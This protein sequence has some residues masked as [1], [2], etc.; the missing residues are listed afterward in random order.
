MKE[1]L[2]E[3]MRFRHACKLFDEAKKIPDDDLRFILEAGR[4]SQ[5]S[6]GLEPWRFIV[7]RQ[8]ELKERLREACF[9]QAQLTTCS[10]VVAIAAAIERLHP[11]SEYGAERFA[12]Y[13]ERP[14]VLLW[15]RKF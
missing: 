4:L 9:G 6:F 10:D 2:L 14:E 11:R 7:V 12:H 3:A 13:A 5:S 15:V 1:E 8:A